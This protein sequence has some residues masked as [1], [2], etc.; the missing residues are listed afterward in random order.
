M[1]RHLRDAPFSDDPV[2]GAPPGRH[3]HP[4]QLQPGRHGAGVLR[5]PDPRRAVS[6]HRTAG[7]RAAAA[8]LFPARLDLGRR[9]GGGRNPRHLGA[10]QRRRVAAIPLRR[11]EP[12]HLAVRGMATAGRPADAVFRRPSG[13]AGDVAQLRGRG[14]GHCPSRICRRFPPAYKAAC[15]GAWARASARS[16]AAACTTC[17][18]TS[19]RTAHS[20]T[21]SWARCSRSSC[22][23][24]MK[25]QM[26][27][28]HRLAHLGLRRLAGHLG[29]LWQPGQLLQR[30]HRLSAG[31]ARTRGSGGQ[32]DQPAGAGG[33]RCGRIP[34][35]HPRSGR[36]LQPLDRRLYQHRRS[37][38][39]R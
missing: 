22:E 12:G 13:P 21:G 16:A 27:M 10:R 26:Q 17:T 20:A 9:S 11:A 18:T 28:Q 4:D 32:S 14:G 8:G 37:T 15:A 23:S 7:G 38:C 35:G 2:K 39:A 33:G 24:P 6:S 36:R 31:G 29:W 30:G 1:K 34:A 3:R 25:M 5:C 19:T